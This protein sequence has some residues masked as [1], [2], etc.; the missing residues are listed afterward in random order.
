V[1]PKN[2]RG[3][4]PRRR[5]RDAGRPARTAQWHAGRPTMTTGAARRRR[6]L[7]IIVIAVTFLLALA[8]LAPI[9][10]PGAVPTASGANPAASPGT[11]DVR[12]TT[13]PGL[14]G[15]PIFALLG[16][17]AVAAVAIGL[18]LA[19]LRLTDDR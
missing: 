2:T 9:L 19:Y 18:T 3:S 12:T 8:V 1:S 4:R 15:D 11:G 17:A 14:V 6:A 7:V 10:A 5:S 13:A 16:V